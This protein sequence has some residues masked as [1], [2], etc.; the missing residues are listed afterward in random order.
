M[1]THITAVS[2][3][4]YVLRRARLAVKDCKEVRRRTLR[5]RGRALVTE[6]EELLHRALEEAR[7]RREIAARGYADGTPDT[8]L[9][10]R[11][12]AHYRAERSA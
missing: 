12:E 2:I 10:A 5:K 3:L 6:L 7:I 11:I 4:D 8:S 1:S 9:S